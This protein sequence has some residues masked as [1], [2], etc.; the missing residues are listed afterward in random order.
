MST[1]MGRRPKSIKS[2]ITNLGSKTQR[3]HS[4][5]LAVTNDLPV[6]SVGDLE[7]RPVPHVG[8]EHRNEGISSEEGFVF[9]GDNESLTLMGFLGDLEEECLP[10]LLDSDSESDEEDCDYQEVNNLSDLEQF[11]KIL[12]E[13]QRVAIEAE[14]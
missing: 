13:A 9:K 4:K 8:S 3:R 10:D 14:I 1:S 5:S 12:V 2:S 11:T 6:D 7:F